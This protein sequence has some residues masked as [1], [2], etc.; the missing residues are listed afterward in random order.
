MKRLGIAVAIL[1]A[2]VVAVAIGLSF[3]LDA[4]RFKP[5]LEEE[6]SKVLARNVK[7]GEL[8][9]S[10]LSGS[11]SASELSI[12]DDPA[13]GS[14]PFV[15]AKSL[16]A[17]VELM[18]L[19]L[20]RKLNVTGITID[21]PQI[22]LLQSPAGVWNFSTLG[23][24]KSQPPARTAASTASSSSAPLDLSVKSVNIRNGHL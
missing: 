16:A 15:Q 24:S 1:V 23:S 9:F 4:N 8:Q 17:G 18:P 13:F 19:I 7:V 6:L 20:S 12:S 5:A 3:F 11:V 2:I 21:S 10:L 14:S 22:N